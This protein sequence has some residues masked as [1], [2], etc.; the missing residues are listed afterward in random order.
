MKVVLF[1]LGRALE[2]QEVLL[3]GDVQLQPAQCTHRRSSGVAKH[4]RRSFFG[5][6]ELCA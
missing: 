4:D 6:R 1:D 5:R 3:P 2:K